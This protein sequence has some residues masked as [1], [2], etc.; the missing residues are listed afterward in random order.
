VVVFEV[1]ASCPFLD[2]RA[3]GRGRA[4]ARWEI[5]RFVVNRLAPANFRSVAYLG[6]PSRAF[7]RV[8][9]VRQIQGSTG[10]G[11]RKIVRK[12]RKGAGGSGVRVSVTGQPTDAGT[13]C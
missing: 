12:Y 3:A 13:P 9:P 2:S 8:R 5:A 10:E 11:W 6:P 4:V 7:E 1:M